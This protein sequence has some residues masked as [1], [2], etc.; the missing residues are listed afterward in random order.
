MKCFQRFVDNSE[1]STVSWLLVS[2]NHVNCGSV[3]G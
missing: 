2:V 1:Y 3:R